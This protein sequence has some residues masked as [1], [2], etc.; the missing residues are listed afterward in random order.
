MMMGGRRRQ[1]R[2][3][4]VSGDLRAVVVCGTWDGWRWATVSG[5]L[6]RWESG[7]AEQSWLSPLPGL[8]RGG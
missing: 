1:L 2:P 7:G 5:A 6:R 8:T 3:K 4:V